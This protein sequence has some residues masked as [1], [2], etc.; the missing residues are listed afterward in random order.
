MN[1]AIVRIELLENILRAKQTET[2][3]KV[4]ESLSGYYKLFLKLEIGCS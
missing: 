4:T 2:H 3:S 1:N